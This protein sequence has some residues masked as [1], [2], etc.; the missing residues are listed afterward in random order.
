MQK[1]PIL[2][3]WHGQP[4]QYQHNRPAGRTD[5]DRLIRRVQNQHR[6][7]HDH[8]FPWLG[9]FLGCLAVM[10]FV[11]FVPFMHGPVFLR[12][13]HWPPWPERSLLLWWPALPL[14]QKLL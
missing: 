11:S 13:E 12:I 6:S 2:F 7:L 5:I 14:P 4:F 1:V 10:A 3:F 9:W 8:A